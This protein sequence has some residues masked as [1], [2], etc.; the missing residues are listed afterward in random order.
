MKFART[1]QLSIQ[2]AA[3]PKVDDLPES[4]RRFKPAAKLQSDGKLTKKQYLEFFTKCT[5]DDVEGNGR[6]AARWPCKHCWCRRPCIIWPQTNS[7]AF[8]T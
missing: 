8:T 3:Q 2:K 6:S 4:E 7:R 5:D 1:C